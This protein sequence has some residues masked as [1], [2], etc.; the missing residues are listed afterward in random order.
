MAVGYSAEGSRATLLGVV[1]ER[2]AALPPASGAS[3]DLFSIDGGEILLVG[4]YGK[5]TV[6]IPNDSIDFDIDFDPDTGGA[7]VALASLLAVDN[8]AVGIVYSLNTTIGGALV[9]TADRA[10]NGKLVAPVLLTPG[11]IRLDVAGG[12]AIGT[13][14]RVSWSMAWIPWSSAARVAA[15]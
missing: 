7:D 5:V 12:G 15:V 9:G 13:T 2:A 11:D 6:A 1:T 8:H 4:L 10:L 3:A 14:A